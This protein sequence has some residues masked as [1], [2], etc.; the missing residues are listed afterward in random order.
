MKKQRILVLGAAGFIGTYLV[1]ELVAL[2]YDVTASDLAQ[3]NGNSFWRDD[4]SFV[5]I[6]ITR[7]ADFDALKGGRFDVV[8]HVAACQPAK[9]GPDQ[10]DPADYIKV[11]VLGTLNV[12]EFCRSC[13]AEKI[14]Y[15]SSHR[16]TQAL[17]ASRSVIREED[18]RGIKFTGEYAMFSISESAAQDC[19]TYYQ[20]QHGLTGIIFR[21]PPVYG[22]G[23]HTEIFKDGKRIKTGFQIFIEKAQACEPLEIWGNADIGRDIVYIKDVTSAFVKA[24]ASPTARGLYNIASGRGLTLREQ[25]Q[26]IAEL[27]WGSATQPSFIEVPSRSNDMEAFVY[28]ISKAERE[29]Q[30]APRYDF[31]AMLLDYKKE[32][33]IGRFRHLVD[34][35]QQMFNQ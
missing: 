29:L 1:D 31:R 3:P 12:L 26:T 19:V 14:I 8:V 24:I 4:V 11:N 9:V 35:R 5:P 21:L 33:E 13:S 10:Y 22:Y 34:K 17:W 30:W 25:A 23:P 7:K 28:D 6:D 18:G 15:A 20:E 32:S 16:N 27:Y 2:G